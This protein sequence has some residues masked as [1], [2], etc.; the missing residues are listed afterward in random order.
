[1]VA[2]GI[3]LLFPYSSAVSFDVAA[4]FI[5]HIK[6]LLALFFVVL[7][8][9]GLLTKRLF[10]GFMLAIA[11]PIF[12]FG[13]FLFLNGYLD[14][15]KPVYLELDIVNKHKVFKQGSNNDPGYWVYYLDALDAQGKVWTVSSAAGEG[16]SEQDWHRVKLGS[17]IYELHLISHEGAFGVPWIKIAG[18]Y[19]L[20]GDTAS[21]VW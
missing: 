4:I 12:F 21:G 5:A 13:S 15:S 2:V 1:M 10:L 7:I 8:S 20:H 6:W 18:V 9:T 16:I 11:T 14:T 17:G 19:S 3:A